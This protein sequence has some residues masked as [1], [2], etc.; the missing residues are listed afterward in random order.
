MNRRWI[1]CWLLT[2]SAFG[3]SPS[4]AELARE[5][6]LPIESRGLADLKG[7]LLIDHT[8]TVLGQAFYGGFAAA[9]RELDG[10]QRYSVAVSEIP[11][12]RFGSTISIH[13]GG[14]SLFKAP[15]GPSR[16]IARERAQAVAA[17]LFQALLQQEAESAF[18]KDPDLGPEELQ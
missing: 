3:A 10:L 13:Q 16:Q 7:G 1:A 4:A 5:N 15:L 18:Y 2:G 6:V 8:V 9:W 17:E 11:N 12:A 14:R